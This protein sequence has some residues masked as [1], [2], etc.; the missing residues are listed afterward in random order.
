[1]KSCFRL[2]NLIMAFC[3]MLFAANAAPGQ[4][5]EEFESATPSWKRSSTD[6]VI[7]ESKWT[8]RRSNDVES[9]NRFERIEFQNG[10]G[11][12]IYVM[13]DVAP[14][15]IIPELIPSLRVKASRPGLRLM[16]RVVL[17]YTPAPSGD[18]AMTTLLAG[19]RYKSTGKWETLTFDSQSSDLQQQL[20]QEIWM[21]RQKLGPGVDPRDAYIDKVVLNLYSGPGTT[22]VQIDDLVINGIV[23]AE[24]AANRVAAQGKIN[25]DPNVRKT[26]LD[27]AAG[28]QKSLVERDGTVLL[29]QQT[30]F[31]PRIVQHN[32]EPFDYLKAI[33][34]NTIELKSTASSQQ[35]RDAQKMD[36]WLIC[37]APASVGLS[38]I[39]F[40]F[41]RVLAWSVGND[42]T[43]KSLPIVEQRVREIRQSDQREGRPIMGHAFSNW[44]QLAQLTDVLSVGLQPLGTSFLAS[45][46]GDWIKQRSQSIGNG[47]PIWA[48]VQ[49]ELSQSLV[50]QIGSLAEQS[51]P[52]PV[53]PQQIKFLAYEA[54][55][56][57]ARGL[58]FLSRTRL[59][60][61]DPVT[62]LRAKTIQL[63]NAEIEQIEP[64]AVGGALLGEVPT[65]DD[66]IEVTAINTNRSRL[67]IIQRPTHHEQYVAGDAPI[68]TVSFQDSSGSSTDRPY[69]IAESGLV[70]LPNT[71]SHAG[72]HIQIDR[73]PFSAAVVLTQDPLVVNK[74]TQSYER[75]G[76]ESIMQMHSELTQQ[77][78]AIMQ[79]ID[80]Q[81]GR[82]GRSSAAASS[83]LN[84]AVT[85]FRTAQ[86]LLSKSSPQAALEF[87]HRTDERL[88]LMRREIISEPLGMFQSKISTPFV[89]HCS[90]IPL[91]WELSSRLATAQWN[92]NGLAGGD[93]ENLSHMTSAGWQNRRLDNEVL[94]TKVE[95]SEAATIDGRYGLKMSVFPIN[96][97]PSSVEAT[98]LW[99]ATPEIPVKRGQLVRIHGWVN[100]PEVIR[101][102]HHGLMITD[103]L[104]GPDMS[105]RVPITKGWQEFTLYRGVPENGTVRVTFALTGIGEAMVDEVT[106]R[107]IDLPPSGPRQ[108]RNQ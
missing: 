86:N 58:R 70:S 53:E 23:S 41:D 44:F 17:P 9:K 94:S 60:G 14:A 108:A 37:P 56:G 67:L 89:A 65:D 83:A 13:H 49:T 7:A 71:R 8:Q 96:A 38:P 102:S 105:E 46:Y 82:M 88:A 77:W 33:G 98:P 39:G 75:V 54:V 93:F 22:K 11:T 15:F 62:R 21:L 103:S 100:V 52:I 61:A 95:L 31:F 69:L 64:W 68:K 80:N 74:L 101:G 4:F 66:S 16:V 48:D 57:G 43:A 5:R 47:K 72:T 76:Q 24:N 40:E 97:E 92:P 51:P 63:T 90:L 2:A 36:L 45:Q 73:C 85:S 42:L 99:V 27:Q 35:L 78:L 28:K 3:L 30:P 104:G 91:H 6:C 50:M 10:A 59:D 84:E 12:Q 26:G 107:S 34:F 18:G 106:I 29:V 81:M 19:P 1:M 87:V 79:L 32:G 55:T 25:R 20:Q